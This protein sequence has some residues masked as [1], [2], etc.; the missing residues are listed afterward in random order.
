[1]KVH[2]KLSQH[3]SFSILQY[4]IKSFFFLKEVLPGGLISC[5]C[6]NK[7]SHIWRLTKNRDSLSL[8]FGGQKSK[9]LVGPHYPG[10][11]NGR[12]R[13]LPLLK[14]GADS[15]PWLVVTS[16]PLPCLFRTLSVQVWLKRLEASF[17][18][19][20]PDCSRTTQMIHMHSSSQ[21]SEL[22][23]IFCPQSHIHIL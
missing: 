21:V 12:I 5:D 3:C 10:R 4:K 7:H 13:S 9:M 19:E 1:M 8:S 15:I 2:L 14:S 16:L 22:N 6:C 17:S 11:S 18:Q 20:T 23:H